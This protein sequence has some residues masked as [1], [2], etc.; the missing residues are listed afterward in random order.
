MPTLKRKVEKFIKAL[1]ELSGSLGGE[2][3]TNPADPGIIK[4]IPQHAKFA[5]SIVDEELIESDRA[6]PRHVEFVEL[7]DRFRKTVAT[8]LQNL[9]DQIAKTIHEESEVRRSLSDFGNS[10]R[11]IAEAS[12]KLFAECLNEEP[13]DLSEYSF[14]LPPVDSV[15]PFTRNRAIVCID[16]ARYTEI[17]KRFYPIVGMP[18]LEPIVIDG[19]WIIHGKISNHR[20]FALVK[21]K[22]PVGEIDPVLSFT[23]DGAVLQFPNL[24]LA[25]RFAEALHVQAERD[26]GGDYRYRIGISFGSI[27]LKWVE[28]GT[29]PRRIESVGLPFVE[30]VRLANAIPTG[31]VAIHEKAWNQ[32]ILEDAAFAKDCESRYESRELGGKR[33]E[34][35]PARVGQITPPAAW[36]SPEPMATS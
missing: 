9:T 3:E 19:L 33:N 24:L 28:T 18:D 1:T 22:Y 11:E 26:K 10:T 12:Q 5:Q 8:P 21:I 16:L 15:L 25:L 2:T 36:E 17:V 20:L 4:G 29:G 7:R 34:S 14:P 30:S 23:G 6:D 13:P 27:S 32:L 35:F 31:S